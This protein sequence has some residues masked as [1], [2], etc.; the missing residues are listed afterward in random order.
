MEISVKNILNYTSAEI[1]E[2][3]VK[4]ELSVV[5]VTK[6]V[7]DNIEKNDKKYN[8]YNYVNSDRALKR[9]K[10]VQEKIS[11]EEL[12]TPVAGVPFSVKDNICVKNM[13]TTCSS[14]M[15]EN[16]VA[17]YSATVVERLEKAGAILIGKTNM[18]EFGMGSTT[19]TSYYGAVKNPYNVEYVAGGSSGGS[20][21]AV[22]GNEAF[23]SLGSDTGGSI[24]Q[25]SGYC[26]VI[27]LKP[28]YSRVSRYGLISYASLFDQI[29]PICKDARD[30]VNVLRL[31]S[32]YDKKDSTSSKNCCDDFDEAL[33]E[34]VKNLRIGI[35]KDYFEVPMS[36]EVK[37]NV[38]K[39]L[40]SLEKSGA[41]I[42][43]F[44][45]GYVKYVVPAYYTIAMAQASSNLARYD[46]V[47]YGYRTKEYDE[48]HSMYKK[49]RSEGFGKEVKRRIMMGSFVLSS[50]Y[51]E[52]YYIKA[53]KVRE[54]I[55][56]SFNKAF[57]KYDVIAMPI[58]PTT[59]PRIETSLDSPIDMYNGDIFTVLANL[60]GI[61]SVSV[62]C[63]KD[64]K[65][66]P[67]G[68]QFMANH[69]CE[70]NLIKLM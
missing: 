57:E 69:F 68:I 20:A 32:G 39:K 37:E 16:F 22:A 60:L 47:K 11:K 2:K 4:K 51:Y 8:C 48:L 58:S 42:E 24:R 15:L 59:A 53:L 38:L 19:E 40:K 9:A 70:K 63:G 6:A 7:L 64:L 50:G 27:G 10:E 45:L 28:T 23:F 1:S 12:N 52:E 18:D 31:I 49:T 44:E 21:A 13:P 33:K 5:E 67:I 56:N 61:P 55:K 25:P 43:E 54:L 35:P 29:G 36:S 62:P 46:G 3:M 26:G 30:C 65:G 66:L 41:N 17:P 34:N 14:K